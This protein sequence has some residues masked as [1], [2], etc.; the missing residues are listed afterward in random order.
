MRLTFIFLYTLIST[1]YLSLLTRLYSQWTGEFLILPT[2]LLALIV[3]FGMTA[4]VQ[5][6]AD[7][8]FGAKT[9]AWL[10]FGGAF[11][12]F[13]A[14]GDT[15]S[16]V[17]D[18]NLL[19][20]RINLTY[21]DWKR[22]VI[23]QG[24]F[25]FAPLTVALPFIWQKNEAPRGK[26]T[27]FVSAMVGIILMNLFGPYLP[28]FRL[29]DISLVVLLLT[30]AL[31][32]STTCTR[33]WTKGLSYT[34]ALILLVGWY[35]GTQRTPYDLRTEVNPF[36]PI[37]K[38]DCL[39][40]GLGNE[41][42]TLKEGRLIRRE[43]VDQSALAASQLI[44]VLLKPSAQARITCRTEANDPV[45][46]SFETGKLKG[47]YDALW[48]EVP[49]AWLPTE[50]D[51]FG[52]AALE[53]VLN[54]LAQNGVLVYHLDIRALDLRMFLTR[55]L[56]LQQHFPHIQIWQNQKP[57]FQVESSQ[58]SSYGSQIQKGLPEPLLHP[59]HRTF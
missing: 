2:I 28:M 11:L 10:A 1:F 12:A 7:R 24:I 26:L 56:I 54:H 58:D 57:M 38:R 41:G 37:A 19:S 55:A 9:A 15:V 43:G 4:L 46:K 31:W 50:Q 17:K 36:A 25:W 33:L 39:Y 48:I 29:I 49:P 35:F 16:L 34:F 21:D 22:F 32:I 5:K 52:A 20:L 3:G 30:S 8:F 27:V 18:W 23:T 42:V 14:F 59:L 40:T 6:F 51:Y 47:L 13:W 45:L 53:A 44:P